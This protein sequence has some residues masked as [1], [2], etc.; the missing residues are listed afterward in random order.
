[1]VGF[2]PR[3]LT[4]EIE[5]AGAGGGVAVRLWWQRITKTPE[6]VSPR[7]F[8]LTVTGDKVRQIDFGLQSGP[9]WQSD[10]A[11]SATILL[12]DSLFLLC[13][14]EEKPPISAVAHLGRANSKKNLDAGGGG[15]V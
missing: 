3:N 8:S 6:G 15:A 2:G 5:S 4:C 1:M 12:P 9:F 13:S 10:K 7:A 11:R 14:P